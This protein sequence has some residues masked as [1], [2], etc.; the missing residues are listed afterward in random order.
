M[1]Y[2]KKILFSLIFLNLLFSLNVPP[3][4]GRVNDQVNLLTLQER[5]QLDDFL[6]A[7]EKETSNQ[8]VLL[9]IPS[10]KGESLEGFSI[11]VAEQWQ[12]GQKGKN[13]GL[14]LLVALRERQVRVEVGYGL[15]GAVTDVF[16]GEVIRSI[17]APAFQEGKFYEGF[18]A[19]FYA[20]AQKAGGEFSAGQY[21]QPVYRFDQSGRT[22]SALNEG[23]IESAFMAFLLFGFFAGGMKG[24][25]LKRGFLGSVFLPLIVFTLLGVPFSIPLLLMLLIFGFPFTFLL[26]VFSTAVGSM[27]GG[28]YGGRSFG[29]S[30]GFGGFSGGGGGFGGGGAS[31]RW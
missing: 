8:F 10:L 31:G 27:R 19:A 13:N 9:I 1:K 30:G 23:K 21:Q 7:Y 4:S 12:L 24:A 20:L 14:L 2:F 25:G 5:Q 28:F 3:L 18:Y 22:R 16:S 15:E 29:G 17:L 6:M 26:I 11:R